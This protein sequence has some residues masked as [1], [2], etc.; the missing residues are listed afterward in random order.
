[1][2]GTTEVKK[3]ILNECENLQE[4][5]ERETNA[6]KEMRANHTCNIK[7]SG[8]QSKSREV[9]WGMFFST[10]F[11]LDVVTFQPCGGGSCSSLKSRSFSA[12]AI[13]W[14]SFRAADTAN[15][16][17]EEAPRRWWKLVRGL[18]LGDEVGDVCAD[19]W[20][21]CF[22]NKVCPFFGLGPRG[23]DAD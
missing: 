7:G 21:V 20:Q 5:K 23:V 16:M 17:R 22:W 2:S 9:A 14:K 19:A 1:M 8:P 18:R 4:P 15:E 13:G 12:S 6:K 3:R 11:L 10:A